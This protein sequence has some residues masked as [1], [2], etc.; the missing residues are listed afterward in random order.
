MPQHGVLADVDIPIIIK[1]YYHVGNDI[2]PLTMGLLYC[3]GSKYRFG[4][5]FLNSGQGCASTLPENIFG[6]LVGTMAKFL[7]GIFTGQ[8]TMILSSITACEATAMM[9]SLYSGKSLVV[10]SPS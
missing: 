2:L 1:I 8:D 5:L 7:A 4:N 9:L 3:I 6:H 10:I